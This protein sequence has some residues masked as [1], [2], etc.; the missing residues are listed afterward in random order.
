MAS[1]NQIAKTEPSGAFLRTVS[2][3]ELLL[4][5]VFIF[6]QS[7]SFFLTQYDRMRVMEQGLLG[8]YQMKVAG[9]LSEG[10]QYRIAVLFLAHFIEVH[11]PFKMRQAIPLIEFLAY[12]IGLTSLYLLLVT[13]SVVRN[14]RRGQRLVIYGF[15]F[16]AAQFPVLW[17]FPWERPETLPTAF[18]L[19]TVTLVILS[20]RIS[21]A[22]ACPFAILLSFGQALARTDA[23]MVVGMATVVAA[24]LAIPFGRSRRAVAVL[25]LLCGTTGLATHIYLVHRFPSV[26]PTQRAITL[27]LFRNLDIVHPPFQVPE[28]FTALLP[29]FVSLVLIRRYRLGL[30]SSDKLAL[31]IS[32]I[33][34]PIY[35]TLGILS[36][37]RIFVPY[38][39]LMSPT[40]AKLW[41]QF[42]SGGPSVPEPTVEMFPNSLA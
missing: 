7:F 39:F 42:L 35:M 11:T 12:G 19:A 30:D 29:F 14:A 40:I 5:A 1:K 3:R 41:A 23:P 20:R 9:T 31:L 13:S 38:L 8:W 16:A 25:G 6:S 18:Y 26:H 32:L 10:D 21:M 34:L 2:R 22:L 37:I 4:A 33:Y 15:F 28:F 27:Q 24:V 36:E 17:I